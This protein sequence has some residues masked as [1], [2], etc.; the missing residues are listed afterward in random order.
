[1]NKII[2]YSLLYTNRKT[3]FI[4]VDEFIYVSSTLG[5]EYSLK[6]LSNVLWNIVMQQVVAN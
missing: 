6:Y 1:M 2:Q 3:T 4:W 5:T